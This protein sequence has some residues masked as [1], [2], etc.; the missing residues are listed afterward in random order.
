M[1]LQHVAHHGTEPDN[2]SIC[3]LGGGG[4]EYPFS[5]LVELGVEEGIAVGS[6]E[7]VGDLVFAVEMENI[8]CEN[9]AGKPFVALLFQVSL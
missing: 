8:H 7:G 6:A 5:V 3:L 4:I 2:P 1:M 9:A